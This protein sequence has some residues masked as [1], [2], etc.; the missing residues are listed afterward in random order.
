MNDIQVDAELPLVLDYLQM[1][2]GSR[3]QSSL[4]SDIESL[5][6]SFHRKDPL[7]ETYLVSYTL[8]DSEGRAVIDNVV[9]RSGRG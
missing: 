2:P 6:E 8:L 1:D 9:L 5:V 7:N 3:Q 4:T